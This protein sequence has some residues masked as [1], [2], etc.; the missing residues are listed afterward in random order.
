[1]T[2]TFNRAES[3][4]CIT[5]GLVKCDDKEKADILLPDGN[6][7]AVRVQRSNNRRTGEVKYFIC[8]PWLLVDIF[9]V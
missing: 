2:T 8:A 3:M 7:R 6:P 4:S 1:M 5:A 9:S